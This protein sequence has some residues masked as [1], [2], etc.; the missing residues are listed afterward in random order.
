MARDRLGEVAALQ[1]FVQ[2]FI[3]A[4]FGG[5]V[6][7]AH[8]AMPAHEDDGDIGPNAPDFACQLDTHE[9]G[10]RFIGEHQIEAPGPVSLMTSR[11]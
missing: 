10:H 7:E 3:H 9:I 11:A 4:D 8:A 5:S 2:Y 1:R 6:R